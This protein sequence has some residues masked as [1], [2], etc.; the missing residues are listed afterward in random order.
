MKVAIDYTTGIWPGAGVARY[1]AQL[2]AALAE[3][4]AVNQYILLYGGASDLPRDTEQYAAAQQLFATHPNFH[5]RPLRGPL[6][7]AL[8][9]QRFAPRLLPAERFTGKVD[10]FHAPDFVA[11]ATRAPL[12]ITVHDLS[13]LVLPDCAE[14]GLRRYLT[15][16][17]PRSAKRAQLILADSE[18]TRQDIIHHLGISGERVRVVYAGVDSR[19][20][21]IALDEA[22][23]AALL[24]RVGLPAAPFILAVSRLEPRKNFVRLIEAFEQLI[25]A[26]YPHTLAFSGR[27]GWLYEPIL[28]AAAR[29][30]AR[31]GQRVVFLDH[32][33]DTD[34]PALYSA[35]A[36]FAYPSLY[37]GF[38][39]PPLEAL[40]CGAAVLASNLSSLPEVLGDAAL[41][42]EPTDT[43]AIAA[44]L[45]RLLD[46]PALRD[47]LRQR[48]PVQAARFT[49]QQ[50]A[51][52]VL[53]AYQDVVEV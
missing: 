6:K 34:L 15:A 7:L 26:G 37:E 46:D 31:H 52:D 40:A 47:R 42:V 11:P 38:G 10:I 32:V 43:A 1:T 35:C 24:K 4:D 49:W 23:R 53:R 17:L 16:T 36:A 44:G 21:P 33:P 3:A 18:S 39:L 2:V 12:I 27:K 25:V 22:A 50:A 30:N 13:F 45:R 8:R 5:P 20:Q 19:F 14:V 41:L 28:A 48:G 29:V 9:W 51:T